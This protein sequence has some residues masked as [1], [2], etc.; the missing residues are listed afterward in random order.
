[1]LTDK[2][3]KSFAGTYISRNKINLHKEALE[4]FLKMGDQK[5]KIYC[6]EFPFHTKKYLNIL[7]FT[8][9]SEVDNPDYSCI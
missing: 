2:L 7:H 8:L 5:I 1:M 9:L 6:F 4:K 3:F